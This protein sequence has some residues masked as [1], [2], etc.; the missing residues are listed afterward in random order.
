MNSIRNSRLLRMTGLLLGVVVWLA[1]NGNPPNGNTGAPFNGHCN[2][3]HNGNNPSGFDGTVEI[4][5]LPATIEANTLYNMTLTMT[6]NAGNP[7]KGG[8]QLVVVNGSNANAGNLASVNGETGTEFLSSRE[9][10]EHRNGKTFNGNPIS[11][12][13]NWTSPATAAGNTI[14]VYFIGNFVNGNNNDSGDYPVAFSQTFAFQGPP[15]VTAT[16]TD[17]NNVL[18]FGTNTGSATVEGGGG[19]PPYTY[20][21]SNGQTTAT[22]VNLVAGNYTVTVTGASGS[23]TATATAT[24]TQPTVVNLGTSVA[25]NITCA[26]P[27]VSVTAN[28]SG[29]TSPYSFSWSNGDTGNPAEYFDP[30]QHTVTVTDNNGCTKTAVFNINA[31]TVPPVAVAGPPGTLTCTQTQTS[32]NGTG[33]STGGNIAYLWTA[34]DGGNI[35]S[36]ATSLFPVVNATGTYTLQVTNNTNGCTATSITSVSSNANPPT[37]SATGG[38]LT[39]TV[40]SLTINANSTTPGVTYSWSGPNGFT[41]TQQNPTVNAAGNYVVTVTNPAN[42]CTNTATAV[43]NQTLTP[44][45]ADATVSGVLTC[46]TTTVQLNLVTNAPAPTFSWTGPNNFTSTQQNPSITVPGTYTGT[47]SIS[48][49]NGCSTSDAVV[50]TQNI[51]PPGA[52]ATASGPITC[53]TSSVQLTGSTT[54]QNSTFAWSGPNGFTSTQQNPTVSTAGNYTLTVTGPNGCTSTSVA[55]VT[56]NITPPGASALPSGPINCLNATV[57]LNGSSPSQPVTYAWT[58]PNNFTSTLQNPVVSVAGNY[59]LTVNSGANGCTSTATATV[60]QNLTDPTVSIATPANLNCN[61]A[62]IQINATAS[63]QGPDFTYL[64]TT[65]TG[66]IVSGANTLTPVVNAAGGYT[67]LITNTVN[68]CTATGSTTVS[69]S[70]AVTAS[71]SSTNISCNGGANGTATVVAGGGVG[72]FTYAWNNSGTTATIS[73]LPAGTY[74]VTVADGENCTATA[75]ATVSQPAVLLANASATAETSNGANDG[76]ATAAPSG[77]T[78]GYTYLWSTTATTATITNL[79]PGSY[80]VTVTDA[81]GCTA[82]QTVTVNSFNC[83]LA[84]SS[85]STNVTCNGQND[86]TA[87]VNVTGAAQPVTYAWSNG[88]TTASVD[89]LAPGSYSVSIQDANGCPASLSVNITEPAVLSANA[90]ATA[91]TSAN[92]NDGTATAQPAGGT[93]PYTYQWSNNGTTATITGLAPGSYSVVVTDENGCT[94]S[95]TVIV[96]SF[97]CAATATITSV[98]VTCPEANDGQA[99][100]TIDGGTLPYEYTW[101]NGDTTATTTGLSTGIYTVSVV[102][103][104]GCF[105]TQTDTIVSGDV[106]PPVII[107][108]GDINLCGADLVA[109]PAPVV[110]DNCNL[111]GAQPVLLSGLPSGSPFNDGVTTQ[112]FQVTDVSGN[113]ASCSFSVTINPLP[114]ILIDGSTNDSLDLGVGT[115]NVTPIGGTSPYVFIWRRNGEF[116]SNE[117]DLDSLHAGSYSLLIIDSKGC[118]TQLAPINISTTV[119]TDEPGQVAVVRLWPNP[120]KSSFRLEMRNLQAASAQIFNSQGR[121]A[122]ALEPGDLSDEIVVELLPGGLYYLKITTTE[123]KVLVVKWVKAD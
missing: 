24:V 6:P 91:E 46:T 87:T 9:Y 100:V 11:W 34:S 26:V 37:A 92:A 1:N 71:A 89:S 113:T 50:V 112:V 102:D 15:P 115:I 94:S 123:G 55:S 105:I 47:V 117:E 76:T 74:T 25:G 64:W 41:S 97:N 93:A 83:N 27:S 38:T 23:G 121:L 33:S 96:N 57:I 110:S 20:A 101:S 77:G 21:W 88:E 85:T 69:Q 99:T 42:S 59:V 10:V 103:A 61:N 19:T 49:V 17:I 54:T 3:C 44:P 36:G 90:T 67:L 63:S 82:I 53:S 120:V 73:N 122:Q 43:V 29:G 109:Y 31:N 86:G 81:N 30:G 84:A 7:A 119:D 51:V 16:I 14:K 66:N 107:C 39:C 13:F 2:S 98:N 58:G 5:G 80:S 35:V 45:S 68:G 28:A 12:D 106:T 8:F 4:S 95:Q 118:Q 104:D 75:T 108:P 32:L 116:Y 111:N 114:D 22:A 48:P 78:P 40:T 52:T 62:T 56:Q 60:V 70:P 65:T 72:N 18:C 79:T